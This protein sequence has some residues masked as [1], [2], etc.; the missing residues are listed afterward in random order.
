MD[1]LKQ[2]STS[3]G[4]RI[5]KLNEEV[6]T[7]KR[8]NRASDDPGRISQ[9]HNVR[10][11][12]NNQGVYMKNASQAEQL[13]NVADTAIKD[14]H[15]TL[16]EARE[17]AVQFANE[18]YNADQRIEAGMVTDTLFER[19]VSLTNTKFN[20]RHIFAGTAYDDV[21]YDSSGTYQGSTDTP[22]ATVGD[23]LAVKTGFDGSDL[24]T[25]SSDMFA[26]MT[27]LKTALDADDTAG[28]V[29]ALDEIDD[30]LLDVEKGM[31]EIGGE[32]RRSI[33]ANSLASNLEVELK[34]AK[35]S[36][37]ETNVVDAY[38]RLVQ[39]QTN[40]DAA[41]QVTSMQ[42]YSGLFTRI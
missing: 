16:T 10:Q 13:L 22:E 38:S 5:A 6:S 28:I 17:L 20:E 9:L 40:F 2:S 15:R 42:R 8:I 23:N 29:S 35:A 24:L 19:A 36:I 37:E 18:S 31:V 27:N 12:L 4:S 32:M 11:Q 7:G 25:G 41:M 26:A 3:M 33:D 39:L 14:I 34:Q 30:A 1:A 21:A